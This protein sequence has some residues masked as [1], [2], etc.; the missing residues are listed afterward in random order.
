MSSTLLTQV[1]A[2]LDLYTSKKSKG[3]ISGRGV[4]LFKGSGEDFDDLKL[5]Q[6]GDKISDIDWKA[7]ARSAEPLIRQFNE[8]RVR[9]ICIVADTSRSM[10]ALAADETKKSAALITAAGIICY[11]AM[12][13]G[14]LVSLVAGNE[15]APIQM[16]F[17][18]SRGHLELLLSQIQ[19][20]TSVNSHTADTSWLLARAARVTRRPSLMVIITDEAHP[21]HSEA[22]E[23]R[24]LR[25]RHDVLVIRIMDAD[26]LGRNHLQNQLIDVIAPQDIADLTRK[27]RQ[28]QLEADRFKFE[29]QALINQMLQEL[30]IPNLLT[31]GD[32]TMVN[33]FVQLLRRLQPKKGGR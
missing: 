8:E 17:R 3:L 25:L 26:P 32:S 12:S 4:S 18:S 33:D 11:I 24:K 1:S 27:S 2:K 6:P 13:R 21:H 14:D 29:R 16:P 22:N 10:A 23:L 7:T 20:N 28:V 5:Y 19:K 15:Q 30:N 9:H 31:A